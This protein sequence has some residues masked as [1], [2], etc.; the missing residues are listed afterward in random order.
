M[1]Q[2]IFLNARSANNLT[3]SSSANAV[4]TIL[5]F[6]HTASLSGGEVALLNMAQGL[7]RTHF[8]PLVVLGE[9]GL[10]RDKLIAAGIETRVLPL[11]A[12]IAQ[13]RKDALGTGSLLRL[14]AISRS[15][16]YAAQLAKVIRREN[17]A[18]V[19]CN[20]LK[21]DIIGGLAARLA[22]V[23]V[24]WH[25]RDR[26][27]P[28]YLPVSVVMLFRQL[29]R[30]V[31]NYIIANSQATLQTLHLPA[32]HL[33]ADGRGMAGARARVVHD[34]VP[35]AAFAPDVRSAIAAPST[36]AAPVI[37]LIGRISPW[38]GQHIFIEMAAAV[39][40]R[41]PRARFVIC[42]AA[43]FGEAA[44]EARVRAQVRDLRLESCVE[45][46][47][48]STEV[49]TEIQS[50]DIVVH[51][52]T[53]GEPFGQ[54]IVE[55]MAGGK[56]VVATCG[57]G[58]PEIIE[59]GVTGRLVPM[60]DSLKLTEAVLGLLCDPHAAQCMAQAGYKRA[61]EHFTIAHNVQRVESL[62]AHL[63]LSKDR[64]PET[65]PN[66]FPNT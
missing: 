60:N 55:G 20:S 59:D 3:V 23:P 56:P 12:E 49:Y 25:V 39:H 64:A 2:G 11:S 17:A 42:G 50:L 38:K 66:P 43:L 47:G 15:A 52:S 35:L 53:M 41:F 36:L 26:I 24:L 4:K 21:A 31:P 5:F 7:D 32:K 9:A 40:A 27:E 63:L 58:V 16:I 30:F 44:Y 33:A 51:A 28:D 46:T 65:L 61:Q 14:R 8:R 22:R 29:C 1:Q 34:G 54:V 6:D 62:Y 57:G 18:L 37:G 45:F 13:A 48:F 10:L 19:H